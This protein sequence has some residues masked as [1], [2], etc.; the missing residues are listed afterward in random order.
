MHRDADGSA[1][2]GDGPG[3]GLAYPPGGVG[4]ELEAPV[5]L[6]LLRCLHQAEVAFLDQIEE[7][8]APPGIPLCH[9]DDEAEV[10][11]A[12]TAAGVLVPCLRSTGK[13]GFLFRREQRHPADL[14]QI[15]LHRVVQRHAFGRQLMLELSD[16]LFVQKRQLCLFF[17]HLHAPHLQCGIQ[18]VQPRRVEVL[19][20]HG[21]THLLGRQDMAAR[22]ASIFAISSVCDIFCICA[23]P[24]GPSRWRD[25]TESSASAVP[26]F[27]SRIDWRYCSISL[28]DILAARLATGV[29]RAMR[30]R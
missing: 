13:G 28:V 8:Q 3:D 2:V 26:C 23:S 11:F 25:Q 22:P 30:S 4:R 14:F 9:R 16:L 17:G 21:T 20:F 19:L 12:E 10:R 27:C 1:L 24:S 18:F 29:P 6:E 15:G 7:G 5:R